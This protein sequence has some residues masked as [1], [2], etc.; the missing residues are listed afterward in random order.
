[1]SMKLESISLARFGSVLSSR[2]TGR[3]VG[4]QLADE[5]RRAS[6][7]VDFT[8]VEV[9]TP[10][11]LDEVL[12]AV[13]GQLRRGEPAASSLSPGSTRTCGKPSTSSWSAIACCS[14]M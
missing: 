9:V 10:P 13:H 8:G 5:L 1:M 6:M 2:A 14:G 3:Q 7:L 11:F 12:N 4:A